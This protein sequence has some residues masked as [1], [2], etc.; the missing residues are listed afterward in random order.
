[1]I[2]VLLESKD[3]CPSVKVGGHGPS[4]SLGGEFGECMSTLSAACLASPRTGW[5]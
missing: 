1:M 5:G 2:K 3:T 4:S